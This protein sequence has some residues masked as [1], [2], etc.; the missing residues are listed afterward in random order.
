MNRQ[1][2]CCVALLC[3][4]TLLASSCTPPSAKPPP[5][6]ASRFQS[7][8]AELR[9]SQWQRRVAAARKLGASRHADAV[10]LL[11]GRDER[12]YEELV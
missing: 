12:A 3:T 8:E 4:S 7:L 9:A 5:R 11:A 6:P 2:V 10:E 1:I